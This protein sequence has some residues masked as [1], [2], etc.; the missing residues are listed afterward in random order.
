M[1]IRLGNSCSNCESLTTA[2]ECKTH[3]VYV[4]EGHTCDSFKMKASLKND[5]N[6]NNCSR[7]EGPTCTNPQK[8]VA[9]M[10]CS[11]W[12]PGNALA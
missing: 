9:D 10:L 5:A 11:S 1:R 8:A 3:G 12:A 7:Y 2:Q 6:C 4:N